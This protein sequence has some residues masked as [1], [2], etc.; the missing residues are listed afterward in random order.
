MTDNF[1]LHNYR[2]QEDKKCF[3]C[4]RSCEN[5]KEDV[6]SICKKFV[7]ESCLITCQLTTCEYKGDGLCT[8]CNNAMK[9]FIDCDKCNNCNP[10]HK[11]CSNHKKH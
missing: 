2:F 4:Y 8:E 7:C 11:K 9:R 3:Y 6:C 1:F 10:Y 5:V